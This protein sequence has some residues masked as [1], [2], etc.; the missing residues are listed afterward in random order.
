MRS[1]WLRVCLTGGVQ[2]VY[3]FRDIVRCCLTVR[4]ARPDDLALFERGGRY[5]NAAG[6]EDLPHDR[7]RVTE[8]GRRL[9]T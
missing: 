7:S 3:E 1:V 4:H 8:L 9:D 6:G 5:P 2:S